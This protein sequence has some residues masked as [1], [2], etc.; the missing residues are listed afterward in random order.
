MKSAKD[1]IY[2]F[3]RRASSQTEDEKLELVEEIE[4]NYNFSKLIKE[5]FKKI[6]DRGQFND[7]SI[8]R[9]LPILF[10]YCKSKN[11]EFLEECFGKS[12]EIRNPL[13]WRFKTGN[14]HYWVA[15]EIQKTFTNGKV[16]MENSGNGI[17]VLYICYFL[18]FFIYFL[19]HR[20]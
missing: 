3:L 9:N 1:P 18:R 13:G 19:D 5:D 8:R 7:S 2:T 12:Y 4:K 15:E 10:K 16:S 11:V 20:L 17:E 14:K 6:K